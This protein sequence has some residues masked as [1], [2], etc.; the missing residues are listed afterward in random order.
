MFATLKFGTLPV[1][2][3]V[4]DVRRRHFKA[5]SGGEELGHLGASPVRVRQVDP[6]VP[7]AAVEL[8]RLDKDTEALARVVNEPPEPVGT[9]DTLLGSVELR[10]LDSRPG[11][12]TEPVRLQFFI[13]I[14]P[15]GL[16]ALPESIDFAAGVG[17]NR[18]EISRPTFGFGC[19]VIHGRQS[20]SPAGQPTGRMRSPQD[21]VGKPCRVAIARDTCPSPGRRL[22]RPA[23]MKVWGG[24][25]ARTHLPPSLSGLPRRRS[26]VS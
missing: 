22:Y 21:G 25:T 24:Y 15:L 9:D 19:V 8:L 1:V 7:G 4:E 18:R 12:V 26:S 11:G 16:P 10:I 20:R 2:A 23:L 14:M 13:G 17:E 5:T 3:A 6:S